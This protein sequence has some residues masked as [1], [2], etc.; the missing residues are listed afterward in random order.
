MDTSLVK[1]GDSVYKVIHNHKY[2]G[3]VQKVMTY[4][5][6]RWTIYA[7]DGTDLGDARTR[8]AAVDY[9]VVNRKD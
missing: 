4:V 8:S 5:G 9:L 6:T 1:R 3:F 7:A 2:I